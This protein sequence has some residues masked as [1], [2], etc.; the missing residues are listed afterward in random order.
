MLFSVVVTFPEMSFRAAVDGGVAG[1]KESKFNNPKNFNLSPYLLETWNLVA[2]F[3]NET[4]NCGG[5]D[6]KEEFVSMGTS[7]LAFCI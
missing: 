2:D 3:N 5:F 1:F 6:S 7:L 4:G